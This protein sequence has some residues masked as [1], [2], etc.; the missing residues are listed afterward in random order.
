M[1]MIFQG[2]R[3]V[4]GRERSDVGHAEISLFCYTVGC[5]TLLAAA[6]HCEGQPSKEFQS[7][8]PNATWPRHRVRGWHTIRH[9]M[10][11]RPLGK[12][13]FWTKGHPERRP[14]QA[15]AARP[16]PLKLRSTLWRVSDFAVHARART[17]PSCLVSFFSHCKPAYSHD[18]S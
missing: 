2:A 5:S 8:S 7:V 4:S 6:R 10:L 11:A 18:V 1:I 12:I 9:T 16:Q 3:G 15:T 14:S 17:L 13:H